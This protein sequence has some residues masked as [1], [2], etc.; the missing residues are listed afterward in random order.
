MAYRIF[1]PVNGFR[2]SGTGSFPAW[3]CSILILLPLLPLQAQEKLRFTH[4]TAEKGLSQSSVRSII[5]DRYGFMWFGTEDGLNRFDGQNFMIYRHQ[6]GDPK[7]LRSSTIQCLYEDRKGNLWVGTTGGGLSRLDRATNTFFH[8]IGEKGKQETLSDNSIL[9]ILED[10]NGFIWLATYWNLN[11]LDPRT[12][13]VRQY[14]SS[15][16]EPSSLSHSEVYALYEDRDKRIWV[17][18]ANGLNRLDPVSGRFKRFFHQPGNP[19]SLSNNAI[20]TITGDSEGHLWIG[21]EGGGLNRYDAGTGRFSCYRNQPGNPHSLSHDIISV[22]IP[23]GNERLWVGT[24]AGVDLFDKATGTFYHNTPDPADPF[25]LNNNSVVS[26]YQDDE[27][28]LWVGT[29]SG[30]VNKF[31]RHLSYFDLYRHDNSDPHT[32]S[33]NVVTAFF[34][35][36][37]GNIWIG[38]DGGG[39]NLWDRKKNRFFRHNRGRNA[40][41]NQAIMA[42]VESRIDGTLYIGTYGGGLSRFDERTGAFTNYPVGDGPKDLNYNSVYSLMEDRKGK[43]WMATIGTGINVLDP[44]TGLIRKYLHDPT[45]PKSLGN[46]YTRCFYED[47]EGHIWIG[48]FDGI[49]VF[50]PETGIFTRFNH[51]SSDIR[52]N[53]VNHIYGDREGNV[54][55]GTKEGLTYFDRYSKKFENFGSKEGLSNLVINAILEDNQGHIWVS[56]LKGLSRFDPERKIFFNYNV[57]NGLQGYEFNPHAGLKTRAGELLFG[58]VNGFNSFMP[59][60]LMYNKFAP[61]VALTEFQLFNKPQAAGQEGSPLTR[62]IL[63]TDE[64]RLNYNQDVFSFEFAALNFTV[65]EQNQFAYKLEGFDQSWNYVGNEKKATYTNLDPGEYVFRVKAANNDAVWNEEGRTVRI[66]ITPPFWATWWFRISMLA[67]LL[68]IIYTWYRTRVKRIQQQKQMLERQVQER[69]EKLEAMTL[70]ERE[71]RL[72]AERASREAEEANRAKSVFL[73]TMSHEIRTPMNGVIGTT[74]LLGQTP[75]TEEQR[76]YTEIIRSSGE[77]LLSVIN[78]ILDFSKIESGKMELDRHS[79]NLRN[80]VEE[81]LDLFASKAAEIGLDLIYEMEYDVPPQIM[82]DS[83]RLKQVL[84]NLVGNA[85]KFTQKGEIFLRVRLLSRENEAVRLKFEVHDT[86]IGIPEDKQARLFKAFSQVDSSTTRKYGGTGLGLAISKRIVELMQGA[87]QV[88]SVPGKGATFSFTILSEISREA[89]VTLAVQNLKILEGKRVLI[90]D[91][92]ETNLLILRKQLEHWKMVPVPV[93][94]PMAALERLQHEPPF[95]LIISDMQMPEMDGLQ[96]TRQCKKQQPAVPVILLSSI[97]DERTPEL[98]ALFSSI[99]VKPVKHEE[100]LKA[101][102]N[103]FRPGTVTAA[104]AQQEP[105]LLK[106]NFAR[107]Y[108]IR[109]LI[110][111]DNP[112]NQVLATMILKKLGFTPRLAE[113]GLSALKAV[114]EGLPIDLILMDVQMPEMDGL[115]ATRAIR[116]LP[117]PQ[118]VIIATTAN[119]LKEDEAICLAAGM[120]DYISK[121]LQLDKLVAL[122]QFWAERIREKVNN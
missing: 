19:H 22:V 12:G 27:E 29:Y 2:F 36:P 66:I 85:V 84:I 18:T 56:T 108:P 59:K 11:R 35:R 30:G 24:E 28:N 83:V 37:D 103:G 47:Q 107:K 25:S 75:L 114:Q 10:S 53:V 43:I 96:F 115:E 104:L 92:N 6:P 120:D 86:G 93:N 48:T 38:T 72:S 15:P 73:A 57:Y 64:I 3:I 33:S 77:N 99:L 8:Y 54:W 44:K 87:I 67:L 102:M 94:C 13:K 4:L 1:A 88:E 39:L 71:A 95:D 7:S 106:D 116:S 81:V 80:I 42:L 49:S 111:E 34:E 79:F 45:D 100:L 55:I 118:P 50:D 21:T 58:G 110:A 40:T 31:A 32:L 91:D 61:K 90:V 119:A 46:N 20:E 78:D 26:L 97:G 122:L 23:A 41:A 52:S 16:D 112:V 101:I 60:E 89:Q 76:R 9:A 113:N 69:T 17:G 117:V 98:K 82:G 68:G 62:D 105:L 5:R 63:L 70:Q 74:S 65:P 121:P 51:R 14:R 109:I